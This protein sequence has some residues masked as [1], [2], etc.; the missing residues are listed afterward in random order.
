MTSFLYNTYEISCPLVRD[1][2]FKMILR[3]SMTN[4]MTEKRLKET[5]LTKDKHSFMMNVD[6]VE[7]S[8]ILMDSTKDVIIV[9]YYN[10]EDFGTVS[11]FVNKQLRGAYKKFATLRMNIEA[12]RIINN[13]MKQVNKLVSHELTLIGTEN[14]ADN[15]DLFLD[16][17]T[18]IGWSKIL[19]NVV[20]ETKPKNSEKFE[21]VKKHSFGTIAFSTKHKYEKFLKNEISARLA[22]FF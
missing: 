6:N 7:W 9:Q 13:T 3:E 4:G 17:F 19:S 2:E 15:I 12:G 20:F 18:E 5:C 21:L 14:T 22:S 16:T 11:M 8:S 10:D 1:T